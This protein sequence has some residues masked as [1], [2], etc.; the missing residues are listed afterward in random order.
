MI[1]DEKAEVLERAGFYRRAAERWLE[2]FIKCNTEEQLWIIRRRNKCLAQ[3]RRKVT[4]PE[5][6]SDIRRAALALQRR[7]GM[8]PGWIKS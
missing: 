1:K 5:S 6:Y 8:K 3:A 4:G 2:V 7:M